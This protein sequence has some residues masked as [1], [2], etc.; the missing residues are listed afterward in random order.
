MPQSYLINR[1]W[2]LEYSKRKEKHSLLSTPKLPAFRTNDLMSLQNKEVI[3]YMF[4]ESLRL[5]DNIGAAGGIQIYK[6]ITQKDYNNSVNVLRTKARIAFNLLY[7]YRSMGDVVGPGELLL[8]FLSDDGVLLA[9]AGEDLKI[10]NQKYEIKSCEIR[11]SDPVAAYDFIIKGKDEDANKRDSEVKKKL[12]NID[13]KSETST[14]GIKDIQSLRQR[15]PKLML[16][17]DK[18]YSESISDH[19]AKN[20]IGFICLTGAKNLQGN[21]VLWINPNTFSI[22]KHNFAIRRVFSRGIEPFVSLTESHWS[23][24]GKNDFFNKMYR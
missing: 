13:G 8:Y 1:D 3:Q 10:G 5:L 4:V 2:M 12:S 9:G 6:N 16:D 22:A 19:F 21:S 20:K 18:F 17:I 24:A 7:N 23:S 15:S 11:K 14:R